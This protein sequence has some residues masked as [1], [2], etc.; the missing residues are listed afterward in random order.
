MEMVVSAMIAIILL[1]SWLLLFGYLF[2]A[3]WTPTS[4]GRV[5]KMLSMAGAKPG[6]VVYDLGSGDG[7]II[8]TAAKEFHAK[9]VG[10]EINPLWVLWTYLIIAA[11][12]LRGQVRVVWGNFFQV[13]LGEAD[14]VM[15]FLKQDT[16][17]RLKPKL[18]REL[19]PG[20]RVVSYA[21]TL[22]GWNPL[23]VD[24]ELELFLYRMDTRPRRSL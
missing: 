14:I 18:E 20:T 6:E 19:K 5:R 16:N 22:T 7:R 11:L 8:M 23:R 3:A 24:R 13:N 17:D 10:I 4:R 15:L 2:G 12:G 1:V 21:Y 9:A